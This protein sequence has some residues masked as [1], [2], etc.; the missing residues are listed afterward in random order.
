MREVTRVAPRPER[1]R[2]VVF[3]RSSSAVSTRSWALELY[4]NMQWVQWCICCIA[5]ITQLRII[6]DNVVVDIVVLGTMRTIHTVRYKYESQSVQT[7]A[8]VSATILYMYDS[9]CSHT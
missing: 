9:S 5:S 4:I 3:R 8:S 1:S 6:T 7:I 2:V